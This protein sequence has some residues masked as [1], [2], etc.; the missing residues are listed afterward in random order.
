[1]KLKTIIIS[2]ILITLASA[3]IGIRNHDGMIKASEK[4]CERNNMTYR[5]GPAMYCVSNT[6][7]VTRIF[8]D[9]TGN[10]IWNDVECELPK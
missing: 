10:G 8:P 9:C 6:G 2:I 3:M 5:Q 7:S 4:L 1:M